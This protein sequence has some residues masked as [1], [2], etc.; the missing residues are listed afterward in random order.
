MTRRM[1][2]THE[3]PGTSM[4]PGPLPWCQEVG[5]RGA[6]ARRIRVVRRPAAAGTSAFRRSCCLLGAAQRTPSRIGAAEVMR[7]AGNGQ[8][9]VTG[10]SERESCYFCI[11]RGTA[12]GS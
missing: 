2:E 6:Q 11:V 4:G 10:G 3:R 7:R 12:R 8:R 9:C 5:L 1:P